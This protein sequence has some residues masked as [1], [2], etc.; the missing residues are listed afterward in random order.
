MFKIYC[1]IVISVCFFS[2]PAFSANSNSSLLNGN[3]G[4]NSDI[5]FVKLS[6]LFFDGDTFF[7]FPFQ[8]I[9]WFSGRCFTPSSNLPQA[10]LF[11]WLPA[12]FYDNDPNGGPLFPDPTRMWMLGSDTGQADEFDVL[13]SEKEK[14]I[15]TVLKTSQAPVVEEFSDALVARWQ[16]KG[17]VM[18]MRNFRDYL[19]VQKASLYNHF[20]LEYCYYFK[21]VK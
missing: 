10:S 1:Y 9:N 20:V 13:T 4:S 12:G 7:S 17:V 3:L 16:T 5:P 8:N 18:A 11:F 2:P 15:M 21:K 14:K 6:K 19:I